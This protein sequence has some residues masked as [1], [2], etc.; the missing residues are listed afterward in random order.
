MLRQFLSFPEYKKQ[1]FAPQR[2]SAAGFLVAMHMKNGPVDH[3]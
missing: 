1:A 2:L 3:F